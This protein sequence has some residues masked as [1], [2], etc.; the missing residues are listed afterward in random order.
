M[1]QGDVM[2][3]QRTGVTRRCATAITAAA[4][5]GLTFAGMG[6]AWA[7]FGAGGVAN[8]FLKIPNI[9]G[10][11]RGGAY[12]G[13]VRANARLWVDQ[14]PRYTTTL[15]IGTPL[16]S[17]PPGP[18]P[19]SPNKLAIAIDKKNP[20]L[21]K[22]MQL[23]TDKTVL[24]EVTYAEP[25]PSKRPANWPA[26]W[27]Y[28]LKDVQ[29]E[30]CD[31][32]APDAPEQALVLSFKDIEWLNYD[33][34]SP[35]VVPMAS[36]A[37]DIPNIVP[38]KDTARSK[39]FVIT[40]FG[41][42]TLGDDSACPVMADSSTP[43]Q[44]YALLPKDE[45]AAIRAKQGEKPVSYGGPDRNRPYMEER[46]PHMLSACAMPGIVPDPGHPEP[47]STKALGVNLD[48]DDGS[49]KP[50]GG[51]CKHVNFVSEDGSLK[52]VDNQLYR[53]YGCVPGFRGKKGYMNQTHN[54]R[55]ADGNVVTL[56]RDLGHR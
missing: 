5:L 11:W 19:G 17:A 10:N 32:V 42:A 46:G 30:D 41:Y 39:T 13:W 48:G 6:E 35:L 18:S 29:F 7:A 54:A 22:L 44:F 25:A 36:S 50:P 38:D 47:Q 16:V 24:P 45:A 9:S 2:T 37:A 33:S 52:G 31:V 14:M 1:Y 27:E 28:K 53:V 26:F 40:W 8:T 49:G 20:D 23:C 15:G 4:V 56:I 51:I 3:A 43:Q 34:K 12:Q 21:R 55:R